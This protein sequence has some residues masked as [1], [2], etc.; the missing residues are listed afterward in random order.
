MKIQI[1]EAKKDEKWKSLLYT[2]MTFRFPNLVIFAFDR[3][4]HL[5]DQVIID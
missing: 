1:R 5:L 4:N 3:P 2:N